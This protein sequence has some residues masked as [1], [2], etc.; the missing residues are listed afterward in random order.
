MAVNIT[1]VIDLFMT[2]IDDYRLTALYQSS[3]TDFTVYLTS[4]LNFAIVE[5]TPICT[6][7]L[8]YDG[9]TKNFTDTLTLENQVILAQLMVK[10]W[11]NKEVQDITQMSIHIRD[12]DFSIHS[13]ANNLKEKSAYLMTVKENLSQILNDYSYRNQDWSLWINQS[14]N[15]YTGS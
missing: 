1:D 5:F 3:E 12:K 15:G 14:F 13:E 7:S 9:T 11:L 8:V 6:Q 2:Q 10:Y 4:F